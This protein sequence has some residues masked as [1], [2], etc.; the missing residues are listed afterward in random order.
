MSPRRAARPHSVRRAVA[1]AGIALLAGVSAALAQGDGPVASFGEET[2]VTLVELP[3][4]VLRD[5]AAVTG[6]TAA[7]FEVREGRKVLPIVSFEEIHLGGDS[8]ASQNA[9]PMA[10]R[11]HLFLLFDVAFSRR[12][13]LLEGLA[14][15]QRLVD[16][17]D[18]SDLVA[19]AAYV[20][21][22]ELV[23]MLSFTSD[24]AAAQRTLAAM[25]RVIGLESGG[26]AAA[27]VPGAAQHADP[28]R[29]TGAGAEQLLAGAWPVDERNVAQESLDSLGPQS[30]PIV[31]APPAR[32]G[33][34]LGEGFLQRNVLSH[35]S[36]VIQPHV[37]ER[38]RGHVRAMSDTLQQLTATLRG[39]EG[40]KYL[41]L[42]SEGFPAGLLLVSTSGVGSPSTGGSN[43]QSSLGPTLRELRRAGWVL[44]AVDLTGV[45]RGSFAADSLF[46]LANETGGTLVEG[47]ND[48]AKGLG[49][50]LAP[51]A[52][53]YLLHV[54]ADGGVA[55]GEFH[56]L[57]V[58][59]RGAGRDMAVRHR[60]G[61]HAAQSFRDR[62]AQAR[63]AEAAT[64]IAGGAPRD[65]LGVVAVA[66]PLRTSAAGSR[67]GVVIEVPGAA[68]L[69][70]RDVPGGVEVYG[71]AVDATGAASDF[72]SYAI[73]V[74][75]RQM[76]E[77][78]SAGGVRFV[79]ALDL[80]SSPHELRLLVRER[81]GGR[82]SLL[83]LPVALGGT[84]AREVSALFLP[85]VSDPWLV[86]REAGSEGFELHGRAVAPALR[87][88]VGAGGD[89]Q[90]LLVGRGLAAPGAALRSR[91][92]DAAGKPAGG[93]LEVLSVTPGTGGEP[94]L[95]IAT[96]HTAAGPAGDYRLE[97]VLAADGVARAVA[98]SAFRVG[99][100]A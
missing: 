35:S 64:L 50:A 74:D 76:G 10:A 40:R 38:L 70:R 88:S 33:R 25:H 77:R 41:A 46:Y 99:G 2:A 92:L 67:V 1:T 72:F 21:R 69:E 17:L 34:S 43:V 84:D 45:R 19:V 4:E 95:A 39:V 9:A 32:G 80:P 29:L 13:R 65:E 7:D 75:P 24:R 26:G 28:L 20:P 49:E 23:V 31:N 14:E 73:D 96:L 93:S 83:V 60:E 8:A 3:V 79:A 85:P 94:D 97:V 90:L 71:Y 5:G 11:R 54:Q 68:L 57:S 53:V 18:P 37:T 59:V 61:Y 6:L 78:L 48:L 81:A 91:V 87:P 58:A 30:R 63:L 36:A 15:A 56:P 98:S 47:T 12:E 66:A 82:W 42:F 51:S 86:V 89:A 44:H 55:D 62:P 22:G 100:G 52:H 16:G 27:A